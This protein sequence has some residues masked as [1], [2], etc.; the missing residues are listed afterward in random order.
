MCVGGWGR[1][2]SA[3]LSRER[4]PWLGTKLQVPAP[5]R[6]VLGVLP[7]R[8]VA[9]QI[10]RPLLEDYLPAVITSSAITDRQAMMEGAR[11]VGGGAGI[12]T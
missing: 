12:A 9:L 11:G 5:S 7:S 10:S 3:L 1:S 4:A 8:G 6:R 2:S